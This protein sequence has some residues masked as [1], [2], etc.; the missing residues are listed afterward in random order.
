M[1]FFSNLE[2]V[3]VIYF[4]CYDMTLSHPPPLAASSEASTC[5][6]CRSLG[7]D[8]DNPS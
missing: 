2:T 5:M 3:R 6:V 8:V 1:I 7:Y 4:N